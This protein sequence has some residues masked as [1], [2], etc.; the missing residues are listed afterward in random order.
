MFSGSG[1]GMKNHEVYIERRVDMERRH[2]VLTKNIF[3]ITDGR[4]GIISDL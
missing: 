4:K 1:R 2:L 3:W